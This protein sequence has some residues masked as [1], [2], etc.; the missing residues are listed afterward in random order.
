[1]FIYTLQPTPLYFTY[2]W[3]TYQNNIKIDLKVR[4]MFIVYYKMQLIV[5]ILV[6]EVIESVS[7]ENILIFVNV[8][9][10]NCFENSEWVNRKI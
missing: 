9:E 3:V 2:S 1:M 5:N 7:N 10:I 4:K 6:N 8:K